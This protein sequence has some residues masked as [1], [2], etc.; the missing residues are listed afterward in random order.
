M[1]ILNTKVLLVLAIPLLILIYL[2]A[3]K[4][5]GEDTKVTITQPN[6]WQDLDLLLHELPP[7]TNE[8]SEKVKIKQSEKSIGGVETFIQVLLFYEC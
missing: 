1:T 3:N 5:N 2:F 4:P 8:V 7:Q 6:M